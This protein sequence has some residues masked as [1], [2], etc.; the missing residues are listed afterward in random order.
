MEKKE[1][2]SED[3]DFQYLGETLLVCGTYILCLNLTT[4]TTITTLTKTKS[5]HIYTYFYE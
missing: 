3:Y 4:L 5:T 1:F 2:I